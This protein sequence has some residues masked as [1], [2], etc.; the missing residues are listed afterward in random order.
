MERERHGLA[1]SMN[2]ATTLLAL[3]V[4]H[5]WMWGAPTGDSS[6]VPSGLFG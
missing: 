5:S 1:S 2:L 3:D 6:D 4:C